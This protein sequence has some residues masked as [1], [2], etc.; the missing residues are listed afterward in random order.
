M[1]FSPDPHKVILQLHLQE[2]FVVILKLS[3]TFTIIS[4]LEINLKAISQIFNPILIII[5]DLQ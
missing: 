2:M 1:F 3:S 5:I 4:V